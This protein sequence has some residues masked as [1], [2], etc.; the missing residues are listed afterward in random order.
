MRI[1][2]DGRIIF[3][4]GVGRYISNLL[5]NLLETDKN[6]EFIVYLDKTSVMKDYIEAKNCRFKRLD[7]T[8]ALVYEQFLM[9]AEAKKDKIDVL[10]G[11]DN[12]LPYNYKGKKVVTIHD[13]MYI[14]PIEKAIAKPT[15][16]QR[17]VDLY[18]KFMIPASAKNADTVI[19]V[20]EY[21]KKDIM[22]HIKIKEEK[23]VVI[24][25][26]IDSKYRVVKNEKAEARVKE[27]FNITKPFVLISAA[28][29]L[30]KNTI[31]AIEAFNLF[32]NV[33]EYGYQLVI[34]SI[35]KKELETTTIPAKIKELNL[36]KYTVI[37]DYVP[38][39]EMVALYNSAFM[40]LFPSMWEGFGLQVLEAF[41]CGLPVV[42]ADNTSLFEI[43]GGAAEIVD[44]FSVQDIVRGMEELHNNNARREGYIEKGLERV[45]EFSWKKAAQETL[46][47]YK[48][49][50]K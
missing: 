13:T 19:T 28:S 8:N 20:S 23:I 26:G 39:D 48:N 31:R 16:K 38:D 44:P 22:K 45:K 25:E 46:E 43:A 34:T 37:T 7:T 47:V 6:D 33:T 49:L 30:R 41:A 35:G 24:K 32:N 10:H 4:R 15:A 9:P 2:I 27:R 5:K 29:D 1:G 21:S 14:R 50:V 11:T 18:N 3:R 42:T 12:T 17:A 40:F 36:E